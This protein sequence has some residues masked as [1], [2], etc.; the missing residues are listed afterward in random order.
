MAT[1]MEVLGRPSSVQEMKKIDDVVA[2]AVVPFRGRVET[3]IVVFALIRVARKLLE[4]YAPNVQKQLLQEVIVPFLY[5]EHREE[6][7]IIQ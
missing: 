4:L 1:L 2:R 7:L 6:G 5:G 3:A